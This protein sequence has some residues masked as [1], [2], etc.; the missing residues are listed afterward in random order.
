MKE[1]PFITNQ[2]QQVAY[3][4]CRGLREDKR[5]E[6]ISV[7]GNRIVNFYFDRERAVE[8]LDEYRE[9]KVSAQELFDHY[10]QLRNQILPPRNNVNR[11]GS[12]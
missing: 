12:G 9:A 6:G 3:L 2:L 8:L 11:F 10:Y 4:Y 5:E 1:L 7:K